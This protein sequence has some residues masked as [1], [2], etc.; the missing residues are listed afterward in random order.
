MK[1]AIHFL[2]KFNPKELKL[3][4]PNKPLESTNLIQQELQLE[5]EIK[6]ARKHKFHLKA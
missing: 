3:E 6:T 2:H 4:E 1:H 5:E